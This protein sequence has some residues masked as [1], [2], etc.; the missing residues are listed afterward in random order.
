MFRKLFG[1]T[2]SDEKKTGANHYDIDTDCNYC[3]NCGEAYRAEIATCADCS[4]PLMSGAEKLSILKR[5]DSGDD[6]RSMDI[7]AEDELVTIQAGKLG[8][9]K[10]LQQ[11]LKAGYVP[12]IL[13]SDNASK[14]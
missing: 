14:G 11:R 2:R 3:P 7:S 6:T 12:S 4:I 1:L 10:P 13:A 8:I 5:Q 9:L